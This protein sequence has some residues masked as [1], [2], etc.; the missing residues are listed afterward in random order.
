ME[1]IIFSEYSLYIYKILNYYEFE[2]IFL[3]RR[4]MKFRLLKK[5][6]LNMDTF[7][8]RFELGFFP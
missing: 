1:S 4:S 2:V 6:G 3:L 7:L 5:K 8:L